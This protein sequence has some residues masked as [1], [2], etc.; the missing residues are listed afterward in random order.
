V[1]SLL[2]DPDAL[3]LSGFTV[4]IP[5]AKG[6]VMVIP[7]EAVSSFGSFALT[8]ART[9][10]ITPLA[11]N[12]YYLSLFDKGVMLLGAEVRDTAD[13]LVGF[14]KDAHMDPA[15][16][17]LL[18]FRITSD[19]GFLSPY[20]ATLPASAVNALEKDCLVIN[21]EHIVAYQKESHLATSGE[22][23]RKYV[24]LVTQD[25]EIKEALRERISAEME[26]V[27]KE[28]ADFL[29][30]QHAEYFITREKQPL[31]QAVTSAVREAFDKRIRNTVQQA[32]DDYT[33]GLPPV[34]DQNTFDKR[35]SELSG[36]LEQSAEKAI[37][38][39]ET[40]A[41][42]ASRQVADFI[43]DQKK[44]S[45]ELKQ[46]LR[47]SLDSRLQESGSA[48][49]KRLQAIEDKL[50]SVTGPVA[51]N[52]EQVRS[53]LA[54]RLEKLEFD[55]AD[56]A[57]EAQARADRIQSVFKDE[58]AMLRNEID[59]KLQSTTDRVARAL[60]LH[61]REQQETADTL[62]TLMAD[63]ESG[64]RTRI[65]KQF[66]PRISALEQSIAKSQEQENIHKASFNTRLDTS[67]AHAQKTEKEIQSLKTHIQAVSAE[68]KNS[69]QEMKSSAD[70]DTL[71]QIAGL[72]Q[73]MEN[74]T[75]AITDDLAMQL[76]Q[77]MQDMN[78]RLSAMEENWD[79]A[80]ET[81]SQTGRSADRNLIR[82]QSMESR[83]DALKKTIPDTVELQSHFDEQLEQAL[84]DFDFLKNALQ[85]MQQVQQAAI[86]REEMERTA[87]SGQVVSIEQIVA[88][89]Q[90]SLSQRQ[91]EHAALLDQV[92][93]IEQKTQT[94]MSSHREEHAVLADQA[95]ALEQKIGQT[96][97]SLSR[98][99]QELL[100][101]MEQIN[102]LESQ[103]AQIPAP[104]QESIA[105]LENQLTDL[106]ATIAEHSAQDVNMIGSI[107]ERL[108]N[109]KDSLK[110]MRGNGMH[111]LQRL[112]ALEQE[113][114]N[115]KQRLDNAA[116][117]QDLDA[118]GSNLQ[119]MDAM[120]ESIA[121]L[122]QALNIQKQDS[123][124]Q[125]QN[126]AKTHGRAIDDLRTALSE[127]FNAACGEIE[128][129]RKWVVENNSLDASQAQALIDNSLGQALNEFR[130]D[131]ESTVSADDIQALD[132][133]FR[134][135]LKDKLDALRDLLLGAL[136]GRIEEL[137]SADEAA[138]IESM[139]DDT[140]QKSIN[141]LQEQIDNALARSEESAS[142][143]DLDSVSQSAQ[144]AV[145]EAQQYRQE[146]YNALQEL[147]ARFLN[148]EN[149]LADAD[150]T[151]LP[152]MVAE[153]QARIAQIE[154]ALPD[155]GDLVRRLDDLQ[156]S[157]HGIGDMETRLTRKV[158]DVKE[159]T[160]ILSQK[161][162][163][164]VEKGDFAEEQHNIYQMLEDKT[165]R[166]ETGLNQLHEQIVVLNSLDR[167]RDESAL[168]DMEN[169]LA[170]KLGDLEQKALSRTEKNAQRA[171]AQIAED[172]K[173][174]AEDLEE[175]NQAQID[176]AV[177]AVN[178]FQ[179]RFMGMSDDF[180]KLSELKALFDQA[181]D[182]VIFDVREIRKQVAALQDSFDSM[183]ESGNAGRRIQDMEKQLFQAMHTLE[184]LSS[185]P[186]ADITDN[187]ARHGRVLKDLAA[188]ITE[189]E[190]QAGR[191][192]MGRMQEL[193]EQIHEIR[194]HAESSSSSGAALPELT[195][196]LDKLEN[197][198]EQIRHIAFDASAPEDAQKRA[199]AVLS[200]IEEKAAKHYLQITER[201]DQALDE[202]IHGLEQ[203]LDSL[204]QGMESLHSIKNDIMRDSAAPDSHLQQSIDEMNAKIL[205]YESLMEE[206]SEVVAR[207]VEEV[208]TAQDMLTRTRETAASHEQIQAIATRV[209]ELQSGMERIVA[210][211]TERPIDSDIAERVH[212]NILDTLRNTGL[213][214]I[215]FP[216]RDLFEDDADLEAEAL[217]P[218]I[219]EGEAVG[220]FGDRLAQTILGARV[221]QDIFANDDQCII[222]QG[223][224]VDDDVI[225]RAKQSGK[226]L[227]LTLNVEPIDE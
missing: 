74:R 208:Q 96:E 71:K 190:D 56:R 18:R 97:A 193:R 138:R 125:Q 206:E 109:L 199:E 118:L 136:D 131:F 214:E 112:T 95:L 119:T 16:G 209:Q 64:L 98:R 166:L 113:I 159:T 139:I 19:K 176:Q 191:E 216:V 30:Q 79:A 116:S 200:S 25:H 69:V 94:S 70:H 85:T 161:I 171:L 108:D 114:E 59:T 106:H 130:E 168:R 212:K 140:V 120:Q 197:Q 6:P 83:I 160:D 158:N 224:L 44:S 7:V 5:D 55:A 153:L 53:A 111:A 162:T 141:A 91:E 179:A 37:A 86:D 58:I 184:E 23:R 68:V 222:K 63:I 62:Q 143:S 100:A 204:K 20:N 17:S 147:G 149:A 90:T 172:V 42:Q 41:L 34:V 205:R 223:V 152:E 201:M 43:D 151:I 50:E 177:S 202:K 137:K 155:A 124:Q 92:L 21:P 169:S 87:I 203:R 218:E 14:V 225:R 156:S 54:Q 145:E 122:Q 133:R 219:T 163:G 146:L 101:L 36:A 107:E 88:Q 76:D 189:F 185:T 213:R 127:K 227:E 121:E 8:I 134:E 11:S 81:L 102:T 28:L 51:Q 38:H 45:D 48:T 123:E 196:R 10:L 4:S 157:A 188:R 115:E 195:Q 126:A 9:E 104:L 60:D 72:Q 135:L 80:N 77:I 26:R 174:L 47:A 61:K 226:F 128:T 75:A 78:M 46:V 132:T 150:K 110:E 33:K 49:D 52:L 93:A 186:I 178:A 40:A 194:Q 57:A 129:L 39:S 175:S 103:T 165:T 99:Q 192:S 181:D 221:A 24:P 32:M 67:A 27:R 164:L 65:E 154:Q 15:S 29:F 12:E 142:Q 66:D 215:I 84:H 220:I 183:Q 1:G 3:R 73:D 173:N 105:N 210:E 82:I 207:L 13:K 144:K 35:I 198:L 170:A 31:E 180:D 148:F 117:R 187:I 211:I 182:S 167:T 217:P 89:T 22:E 2:I